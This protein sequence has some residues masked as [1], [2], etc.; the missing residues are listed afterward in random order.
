MDNGAMNWWNKICLDKAADE[1]DRKNAFC[2]LKIMKAK[3]VLNFM[4][5]ASCPRLERRTRSNAIH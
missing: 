4:R 3:S 1:D 5:S 2:S